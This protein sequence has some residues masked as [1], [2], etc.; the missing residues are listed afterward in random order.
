MVVISGMPDVVSW[1]LDRRT[2]VG[3]SILA[4]VVLGIVWFFIRQRLLVKGRGAF[5]LSLIH[6]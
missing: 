2:G 4:L 3:V 5:I 6:I 1:G